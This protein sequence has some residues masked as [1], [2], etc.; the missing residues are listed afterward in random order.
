MRDY[1]LKEAL[2]IFC[3]VSQSAFVHPKFHF[4]KKNHERHSNP[5]L[6][7]KSFFKHKLVGIMK[8]SYNKF[9]LCYKHPIKKQKDIYLIAVINDDN[10]VSVLT[11]YEGD[12]SRRIGDNE[13]R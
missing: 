7:I 3:N 1:S 6:W 4:H 12:I 9:K 5:E 8:Q 10:S 11:T 2:N 13:R